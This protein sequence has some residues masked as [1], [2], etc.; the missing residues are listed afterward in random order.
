M[1][2]LRAFAPLLP[3]LLAGCSVLSTTQTDTDGRTTRTRAITFFDSKS[4]LAKLNTT[5]TEK[6]QSVSVS[7][8]SQTSSGTNAV[9]LAERIIAAAVRAAVGK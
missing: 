4:E 7:G 2:T 6:T 3:L 9:D 1:K 5:N 8:L